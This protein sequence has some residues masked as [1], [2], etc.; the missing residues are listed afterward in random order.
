[1]IRLQDII[2][3]I[4]YLRVNMSRDLLQATEELGEVA[5]AYRNLKENKDVEHAIEH[6]RE[7]A[8]DLMICALSL[9]MVQAQI[10][11][12]SK[13]CSTLSKRNSRNGRPQKKGSTVSAIRRLE[14]LIEAKY[15]H[16][17]F[18]PPKGV[19][20]AAKRGLELLKVKKLQHPL[21]SQEPATFRTAKQF[22]RPRPAGCLVFSLGIKSIKNQ[23]L[24]RSLPLLIQ[25]RDISLGCF[26]VVIPV[27][28][29]PKAPSV[30]STLRTEKSKEVATC[31]PILL[32][33]ENHD[34]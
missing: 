12:F 31:R 21:V 29:G 26:G 16:I 9:T 4:S 11:L 34:Y 23:K 19:K 15:D 14:I 32:R 1:M 13:K 18:K 24:G 20:D 10:L 33:Q 27:L 2:D 5:K 17:D 6:L 3:H 25:A 7:E 28:L 22:P 30:N 8:C